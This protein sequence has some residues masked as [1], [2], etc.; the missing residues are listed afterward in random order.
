M[1][2]T[3]PPGKV[4]TATSA[5]WPWSFGVEILRVS[6]AKQVEYFKDRLPSRGRRDYR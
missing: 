6:E 3:G 5:L 1:D 4:G 2:A